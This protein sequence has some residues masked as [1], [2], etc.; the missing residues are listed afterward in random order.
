MVD[1]ANLTDDILAVLNE[2]YSGDCTIRTAHL[3]VV[4]LP[5]SG[6]SSLVANLLNTEKPSGSTGL[7]EESHVLVGKPTSHH[8]GI[9]TN[10][11]WIPVDLQVSLGRKVAK[12]TK[13]F[14]SDTKTKSEILVEGI[15]MQIE[16]NS[17]EDLM[18]KVP[19]DKPNPQN[20]N[21]HNAEMI[22]AMLASNGIT[23]LKDLNES[24]SIYLRDCGGQLEF[25][26]ILSVLISGPS[27][28]LFVLD[29]SMEDLNEPF[30]HSYRVDRKRINSC[31]SISVYD[32][33]RQTLASIDVL[34]RRASYEEFDCKVIIVGTHLD[35]I[36]CP[37]EKIEK[38]DKEIVDII[39]DQCMSHLVI[40]REKSEKR[41]IYAVNNENTKDKHFEELKSAI[42]DRM[43]NCKTFEIQYKIKPLLL[44]LHLENQKSI[45]RRHDFEAFAKDFNINGKEQV[46]DV[47]KFLHY[48]IGILRYYEVDEHHQFIVTDPSFLFQ[49]LTKIIVDTFPDS[50]SGT[51]DQTK[52]L[53]M[54]II[55]KKDLL[56]MPSFQDSLNSIT[57]DPE[58]FFS[59]LKYLHFIAP[60]KESN[61]DMVFIPTALSH[62][63][64]EDNSEGDSSFFIRFKCKYCP[65]GLFIFFIAY[66]ME[67]SKNKGSNSVNLIL[68]NRKIYRNK[69]FFNIEHHNC[70]EDEI[71]VSLTK[72]SY[73]KIQFYTRIPFEKWKD[74][75]KYRE[76]YF[77]TANQVCKEVMNSIGKALTQLNYDQDKIGPVP[78]SR[79]KYCKIVCPVDISE[80]IEIYCPQRR[81]YKCGSEMEE[82]D[83][84]WFRQGIVECSWLLFYLSSSDVLDN[85]FLNCKTQKTIF[86]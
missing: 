40:F 69:V 67:G 76:L 21:V 62:I 4:G 52:S 12:I 22:S 70:E 79:C 25:Q 78:S 10:D 82:K 17:S 37:E 50:S 34:N 36:S 29:A 32:S 68:V 20:S 48:T 54:G 7:C 74:N 86:V 1:S 61:K 27:I 13:D 41:V 81:Q 24:K 66:L 60:F 30:R 26:N 55:S 16:K 64:E 59:F 8:A 18:A 9:I 75:K 46:D 47:L 80:V 65:K 77:N 42:T 57:L 84:I 14:K 58:D 51:S 6:K 15:E 72:E 44:S 31:Q 39:K 5:N 49:C 2:D 56:E 73:I 83:R 11:E 3:M 35:E 85:K 23:N 43:E 19:I 71:A 38:L 45:M 33:F 63:S 53:Q 28:V